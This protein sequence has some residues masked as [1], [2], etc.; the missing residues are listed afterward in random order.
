MGV[1]YLAE[2]LKYNTSLKFLSVDQNEI[3]D[4]GILILANLLQF[5]R[6]LISIYLYGNK[7]TDK[8]IFYLSRSLLSNQS[9]N[10]LHIDHL[11]NEKAKKL[12]KNAF[13]KNYSLLRT[14]TDVLDDEIFYRNRKQITYFT[15]SVEF[16]STIER[17][18]YFLLQQ[19]K[20]SIMSMDAFCYNLTGDYDSSNYFKNHRTADFTTYEYNKIT[21]KESKYMKIINEIDHL[22]NRK[23]F[24]FVGI[25]KNFQIKDTELRLSENIFKHYRGIFKRL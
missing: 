19:F 16:N 14:G 3:E 10:H 5:N 2:I 22:I 15:N 9:V 23:W 20:Y 13:K 1:A 6:S 8:G 17:S 7:I 24:K 21:S 11:I 18:N 25:C 4:G 12:L